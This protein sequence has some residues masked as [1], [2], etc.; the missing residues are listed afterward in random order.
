MPQSSSTATVLSDREIVIARVFDAP[1]ELLFDAWTSP[2]HVQQWWGPKGYE[3]YDCQI[4]LRVGGQFSLRMRAPDGQVHLCQGVYRELLRPERIVYD[5]AAA[6]GS[7]CGAGLPP[8]ATVTVTFTECDGRTTL[9][10][11]TLLPS[12]AAQ[13]AATAAGYAFGWTMSLERL[14]D[15][16]MH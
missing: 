9:T 7:P 14:A 5:G 1:R 15:A 8:G 13:A 3:S 4:D 10:I 12:V 2:E 6:V 16:L 11:H